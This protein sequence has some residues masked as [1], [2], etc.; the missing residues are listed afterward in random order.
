[1]ILNIVKRRNQLFIDSRQV[2]EVTGKRHDHL[3]RD[4]EQYLKIISQ[5]P[6]LGG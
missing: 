2:A 4:I 1:M 5:N 3:I 6:T